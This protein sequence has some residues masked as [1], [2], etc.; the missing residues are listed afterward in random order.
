MHNLTVDVKDVEGMPQD[1]WG[2]ACIGTFANQAQ[3]AVVGSKVQ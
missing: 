3:Q 2:L 1:V